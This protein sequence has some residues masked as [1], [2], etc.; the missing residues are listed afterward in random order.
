MPFVLMYDSKQSLPPD[1]QVYMS[2]EANGWKVIV[3]VAQKSRSPAAL[4]SLR[5]KRDRVAR[6]ASGPKNAL[7]YGSVRE[8]SKGASGR[9]WFLSGDPG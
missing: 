5:D 9:A 1:L 4:L 3:E 6:G 2:I 7:G 8:G